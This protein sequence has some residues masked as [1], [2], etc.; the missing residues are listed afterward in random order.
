MTK[1]EQLEAEHA[2]SQAELS[3][4]R[5]D[6][7]VAREDLATQPEMRERAAAAYQA[8]TAHLST[9][10]ASLARSKGTKTENFYQEQ[11]AAAQE[12]ATLAA[13][14]FMPFEQLDMKALE[15]H[16]KTLAGLVEQSEKSERA[17]Y[18]KVVTARDAR[19]I[20]AAKHILTAYSTF[21]D[22]LAT[23]GPDFVGLDGRD[24]WDA[25]TILAPDLNEFSRR[26]EP[27]VVKQMQSD[28][29]D[30]AKRLKG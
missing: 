26:C 11:L 28:I 19:T 5:Q 20:E 25:M 6:L 29:T 16:V 7:A 3:R 14:R 2:G 13:H 30:L 18:I 15:T 4:L 8:A 12:D 17:S 10:R 24:W 23:D 27:A 9:I 21:L 22:T 1:I